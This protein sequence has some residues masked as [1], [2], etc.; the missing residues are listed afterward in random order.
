MH[1]PN[2]QCWR[3]LFLLL[4]LTYIVCLSYISS[5][6]PC[7]LSTIFLCFGRFV[8]F[9]SL[10]ILRRVQSIYAWGLPRCLF[11]WG[12]FCLKD[13]LPAFFNSFDSSCLTL[14]ASNNHKCSQFF[15]YPGVLMF[16]FYLV[17]PLLPLFLFSHF[18]MPDSYILLLCPYY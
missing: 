4:F 2:P 6:R 13:W 9:S 1:L 11:L 15:V 16:I 14:I 12:N 18:S 3:E 7:A 8:S 10:S 17:I 5:V